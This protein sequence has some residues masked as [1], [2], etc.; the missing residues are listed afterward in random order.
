MELIQDHCSHDDI[1]TSVG[2]E[3]EESAAK[4]QKNYEKL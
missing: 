1:Q 3:Q 4:V 2:E